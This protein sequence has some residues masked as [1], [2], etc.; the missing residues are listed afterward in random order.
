M[1]WIF[2]KFKLPIFLFLSVSFAY[3]ATNSEP[4]S[5]DRIEE[6]EIEQT[7]VIIS[8]TK[9]GPVD[10]LKIHIELVD[11]EANKKVNPVDLSGLWLTITRGRYTIPFLRPDTWYGVR[12][13][14]ENVINGKNVVHEEE[15]MIRTKAREEV[16][17]FGGAPVVAPAGFGYPQTI[18]I[19]QPH[20]NSLNSFGVN[21][22]ASQG[23]PI[24]PPPPPPPTHHPPTLPSNPKAA[25]EEKPAETL[26]AIDVKMHRKLDGVENFESLYVTVSW[27]ENPGRSNLTTGL[28]KLRVICDNSETK[29]EIQLK[30]DE[31]SV[32]IEITMDQ[33]YD[34]EEVNSETHQIKAH[35]SPLKCHRIC[36]KS[37]LVFHTGFG[38]F[39]KHLGEE[40]K[41]I[42]GTTSTTFLRN[43]KKVTVMEN[44]LSQNELVVETE[45]AESEQGVVTLLLQKLG[46]NEE[47]ETIKQTFDTAA[48]NGRFIVPVEDDAIYAVSYTYV[49]TKPFHYTSKAHFLVE[50]PSVNSTRPSSP[51]IDLSVM[52]TSFNYKHDKPD[53]AL[54]PE[55]PYLLIARSSHYSRNDLLVRIEPFCNETGVKF[56]LE[57]RYPQHQID[58][59][60]FLCGLEPKMYFCNKNVTYHK[61][62][63]TL[64]FSTSVLIDLD[65]YDSDTRCLNVTQQFPPLHSSSSSLF[66]PLFLVLFLLS[67][68]H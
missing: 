46:G 63:S 9:E 25:E 51:L 29:E 26:D 38:D 58:A 62:D 60:P 14:S 48:S 27:R 39:T 10:H 44:S 49:K 2:I 22:P 11:V 42:S 37:D 41:E 23:Y 35:I 21:A 61:C 36:W 68:T 33:K 45:V 3:S 31:D 34:I 50:S 59:V 19:P 65:S 30:G 32:T 24:A 4:D 5:V 7:Q 12:F 20:P 57:D 17:S 15:R 54:K 8:T 55:P 16:A 47:M 1:N 6:I 43:V 28:V 52:P 40:C 53:S 67:H 66:A 18:G 64:C 13:R 56:R